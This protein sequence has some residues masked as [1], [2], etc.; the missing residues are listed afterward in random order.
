MYRIF[1]KY[2]LTAPISMVASLL[3]AAIAIA[4]ETQPGV[5][6][7]A[8]PVSS[9]EAMADDASMSQ[10]TSVS[11]LTDVRP[12]DWAF[13]ALQSLVERYGCIVG[14]P[15]RTFRGNQA[16]TRY[17]FAAGLNAC[18]DRIS[19]LI[20]A[21]TADFVKQEDLDALKKLQ[22]EFAA[23]LATL[24]GRVDALEA[25][26]TTL[27][28]QQFST[29]T[30]LTG[31]VIFALADAFG[32]D[33]DA[34]TVFHDRVRLNFLTSFTGKDRLRARLQ[35]GNAGTTFQS[36]I[37]TS[38]GRFTYDG[39]SGN[40]FVLDIL[41]Y[42]FPV[43]DKLAVNIFGANALHHYYADTVNPFFE[44]FGGG[45]GALSRFGERN[46]I[47][48]IGP[49][50][51]G[52]GLN[53]TFNKVF[54]L[55]VGYIA[56]EADNPASGAG[57]FD[58]N[59]SALAQVVIQPSNALK[60]GLTYVHAYDGTAPASR[61]F[62]FAGTGTNFANRPWEAAGLPVS[63]VVSNSYGVEVSYKLFP[64]FAIGGWFGLTKARLIG[65][66]D[67]TILNYA[68]TLAFPDLGKKGN[69]GGIIVG[70]EPYL[71]DLDVAGDPDFE[72]DV[73]FHVE[74]FYKY[75]VTQNISI[76]PGLIW[77][78]APNQNNDNNDVF[79]GTIRTTFTF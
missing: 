64:Q 10:V 63:P 56:N 55:D 71:T 18:L 24:R 50:G 43:G 46:P 5:E 51:A 79:I 69:L 42:R 36:Q 27:E 22:E 41:D 66:G 25:R 20:A 70:A 61:R 23:E 31:E 65:S 4:E 6:L 12:T 13:Q 37:G 28:K 78:T 35:A 72:N 29:T 2:W 11:Q 52:V 38:E 58:G 59:Y 45:N 57:L 62:G 44:G 74:A 34:E 53:F 26:T 3:A 76:T 67:A 75:Q 21:N 73:P 60:I 40:D 77:L 16:L 1:N 68:V 54:K 33:V 8:V 7:E 49:L 32:E 47:Y 15:D 19:E 14:Y 30:K 39:T 48:R 9:L 17:E